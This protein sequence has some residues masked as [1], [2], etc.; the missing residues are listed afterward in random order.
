MYTYS[1]VLTD[2]HTL[3]YTSTDSYTQAVRAHT[4][5]YTHTHS[6]SPTHTH[7]QPHSHTHTDLPS[8]AL[9]YTF[10]H[11]PFHA[12]MDTLVHTTHLCTLTQPLATQTSHTHSHTLSEQ[13]WP[14]THQPTNPEPSRGEKELVPIPDPKRGFW[15]LL[16]RPQPQGRG[17]F[18]LRPEEAEAGP[19][20]RDSP[21]LVP[22]PRRNSPNSLPGVISAFSH[23]LTCMRGGHH[24]PGDTHQTLILGSS[25]REDAWTSPAA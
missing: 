4:P 11:S 9:E 1:H 17:A 7:T 10:S 15:N 5:S 16:R 19:G 23:S 13:P 3:T 6:H 18:L 12:L 21:L 20:S 25:V 24:M 14:R 8:L 2:S 22:R